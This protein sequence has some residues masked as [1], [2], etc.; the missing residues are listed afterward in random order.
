MSDGKGPA[1]IN[2]AVIVVQ[3]RVPE[4]MVVFGEI[5]VLKTAIKDKYLSC[6]LMNYGDI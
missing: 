1:F 6:H 2:L 3:C 4:G 5:L